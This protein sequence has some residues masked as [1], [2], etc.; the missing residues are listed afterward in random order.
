MV[1]MCGVGEFI[2]RWKESS[3]AACP[4]C[5]TFEDVAHVWICQGSNAEERWTKSLSDIKQ[6]MAEVNTDP[7]IRE[8]ILHHLQTW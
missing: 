5:G 2:L 8:T 6:W 1:G 3:T 4:M 7:D